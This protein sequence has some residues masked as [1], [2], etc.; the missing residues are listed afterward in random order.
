MPN[1]RASPI[2]CGG[3]S[4]SIDPD[5]SKLNTMEAVRGTSLV[6]HDTTRF[7][8]GEPC[9]QTAT[10]EAI[11]RSGEPL[12]GATIT[13]ADIRVGELIRTSNGFTVCASDTACKSSKSSE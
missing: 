11:G 2:T 8:T 5:M 6:G 10:S 7:D 3:I 1:S 13:R 4:R 12:A 9:S